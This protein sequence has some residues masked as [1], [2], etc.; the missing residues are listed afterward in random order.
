MVAR[1]VLARESPGNGDVEAVAV[2]GDA[3]LSAVGCDCGIALVGFCFDVCRKLNF[4][5]SF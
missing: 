2:R 4:C 5:S 3:G 1:S